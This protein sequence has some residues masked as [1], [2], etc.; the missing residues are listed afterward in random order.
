MSKV[1]KYRLFGPRIQLLRSRGYTAQRISDA[2]GVTLGLVFYALRPEHYRGLARKYL[3]ADREKYA[4]RSRTRRA[5]DPEQF[6]RAARTR[7]R[8]D[9]NRARSLDRA[10]YKR[11]REKRVIA[12][13]MRTAEQREQYRVNRNL[14]YAR[15]AKS[16]V[17]RRTRNKAARKWRDANIACVRL[18]QRKR[19]TSP[20][21][22]ARKR[23]QV[24]R[25]RARIRGLVCDKIVDQFALWAHPRRD[26]PC[27]WCGVIGAATIEH[28]VPLAKNGGHVI[29]NVQIACGKCNFSKRDLLPASFARRRCRDGLSVV[30]DS[31]AKKQFL[32]EYKNHGK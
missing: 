22:R 8:R 20:Q 7:R 6:R 18:S 9:L 16:P 4:V 12:A 25:R 29:G 11:D 28:V 1:P 32:R 30:R 3:G 15:K 13:R 5:R 26:L 31:S 24:A 2:L 21:G 17:F 19:E 27:Y 14:A 10:R 23:S